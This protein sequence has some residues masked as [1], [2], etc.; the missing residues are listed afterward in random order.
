MML[1]TTFNQTPYQLGNLK[2]KQVSFLQ[3]LYDAGHNTNGDVVFKRNYL[4]T[5][6][7]INGIA[8]APAWIVKDVSRITDRGMYAIP[9][10][11]ELMN[12][13]AHATAVSPGHETDGD[14][15]ADS[16]DDDAYAVSDDMGHHTVSDDMITVS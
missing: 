11:N 6:A 5:V 16:V 13:I 1:P 10:L 4:K 8:W 12:K 14:A 7:N 2:P 3:H 9:E 15:L